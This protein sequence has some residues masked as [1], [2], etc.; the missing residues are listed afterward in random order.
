M[1]I[2]VQSFVKLRGMAENSLLVLVILCFHHVEHTRLHRIDVRSLDSEACSTSSISLRL[3]FCLE[4][5][6]RVQTVFHLQRTARLLNSD[7]ASS[8][9]HSFLFLLHET[10]SGSLESDTLFEETRTSIRVLE[11]NESATEIRLSA[12]AGWHLE[13][14]N[15]QK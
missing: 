12:E 2:S 4:S 13:L 14:Y 10:I 5:Y 9:F 8:S 3:L 7:T 15:R 6:L 1:I 11:V